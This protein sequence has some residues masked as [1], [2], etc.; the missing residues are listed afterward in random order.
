MGTHNALYFHGEL[1]AGYR[2]SV[3]GPC[4]LRR[5]GGWTQL[6]LPGVDDGAASALL[7]SR[8]AP[9]Q[10]IWAIVQTTASAVGIAHFEQGRQLRRIEFG[11]GSWYRVEGEPQPW[12][13]ALFSETELEAAK[14]IAEAE[15]DAE[16][17]AVFGKKTL[18]TGQGLPW[19]REWETVRAALGVNEAEFAAAYDKQPLTTVQGKRISR[20]THVARIAL[21]L[22]AASVVGLALTRNGAFVGVGAM[23]LIVAFGAGWLRQLTHGRW[24]F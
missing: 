10:V 24:F 17:E 12:E 5:L 8:A 19:P 20:V 6:S 23:F 18:E 15:M 1:P 13:A 21:L 11:N 9:G 4:A 16:L 2:P 22:G 7:L 14:E 3:E